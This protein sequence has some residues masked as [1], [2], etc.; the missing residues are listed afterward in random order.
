MQKMRAAAAAVAATL[1]LAGCATVQTPSKQDPFER[2]NRTMFTVNDT[3]DTYALKPVATSYN[4][5]VP[6]YVRERVSSVFSNLGDIYTGAN[7]LLQGKITA[8]TEDVMRFAMNSTFG[9]GG[10]FDFA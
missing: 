4:K 9:L 8:G 3:V 1:V 10:L 7:N 5:V 2:F 6:Q